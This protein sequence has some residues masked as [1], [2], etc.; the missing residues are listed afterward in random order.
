MG[1]K[2]R[3]CDRK[4]TFLLDLLLPSSKFLSKIALVIFT[5]NYTKCQLSKV[6]KINHKLYTLRE[7]GRLRLHFSTGRGSCHS[8]FFPGSCA[9]PP[10]P[11]PCARVRPSSFALWSPPSLCECDCDRQATD[12]PRPPFTRHRNSLKCGEGKCHPRHS[13]EETGSVNRKPMQRYT[14]PL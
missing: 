5:F 3:A 1:L 8:G 12:R 6:V 10:P 2:R 9:P 14:R 11:P 13:V 7:G 4:W